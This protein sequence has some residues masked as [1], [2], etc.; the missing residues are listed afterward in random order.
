MVAE[1]DYLLVDFLKRRIFRV[2]VH[3][4]L[5]GV[6]L[7]HHHNMSPPFSEFSGF[8]KVTLI[9][10]HPLFISHI[11]LAYFIFTQ[12]VFT[13][14]VGNLPPGAQVLIKITYV[15]ELTVDGEHICFSLPGSV[16]PWTRDK[17]LEEVTQ[18]MS[19]ILCLL[20]HTSFVLL[21]VW[22][23]LHRWIKFFCFFSLSDLCGYS[24]DRG[25]GTLVSSGMGVRWFVNSC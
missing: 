13:V 3:L 25:S 16:A 14:S 10:S 6:R 4:L 22:L 8:L 19:H 15:T 2:N 12:D 7:R 23:Q 24:A 21:R 20:L 5:Y 1:R 18:V 11:S 9:R 17:A